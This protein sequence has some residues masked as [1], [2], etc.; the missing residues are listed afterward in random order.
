MMHI[1]KDICIQ[2]LL[3]YIDKGLRKNIRKK[4]EKLENKLNEMGALNMKQKKQNKLGKSKRSAHGAG[5]KHGCSLESHLELWRK[6]N[7]WA[8]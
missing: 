3:Y 4:D 2:K 6:S 8:S 7:T 5:F 1:F